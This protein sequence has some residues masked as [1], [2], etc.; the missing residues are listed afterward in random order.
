MGGRAAL[1]TGVRAVRDEERA[2]TT[3]EEQALNDSAEHRTEPAPGK[4]AATQQAPNGS[5]EHKTEPAPGKTR[6]LRYT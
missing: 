1:E 4:T 2:G 6:H 5:A 3:A